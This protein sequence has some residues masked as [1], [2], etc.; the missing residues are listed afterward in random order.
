MSQMPKG[1]AILVLSRDRHRCVAPLLDWS[2][3]GQCLGRLT[4]QHVKMHPGQR[5]VHREEQILV[6]C[7]GHHLDTI[8]G[9][10]W[11]TSHMSEQRAYLARLYPAYWKGHPIAEI[12]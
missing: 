1:L 12:P 3:W 8:A 11:A 7:R 2:A 9:A 6:L 4:I 10:N 5:R